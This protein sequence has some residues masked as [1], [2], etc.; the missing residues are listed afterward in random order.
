MSTHL[1]VRLYTPLQRQRQRLGHVPTVRFFSATP[2]A[3]GR[4]PPGN[5]MRRRADPVIAA[6]AARYQPGT[7]S[8]VLQQRQI[9]DERNIPDDV[10]LIPGNPLSRSLACLVTD[11]N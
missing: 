7:A 1:P 5:R 11:V 3:L 6:T 4:G 2:M 9:N 8:S 10:G